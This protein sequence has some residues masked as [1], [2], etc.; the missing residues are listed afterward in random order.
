M[1]PNTETTPDVNRSFNASTSV[2]T[3]V[4]MRPIG[5]RS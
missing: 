4:I 3:R 5:L 2:V 1:S